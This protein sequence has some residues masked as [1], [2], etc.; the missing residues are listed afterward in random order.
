LQF[1]TI[2]SLQI[3][4]KFNLSQINFLNPVMSLTKNNISGSDSTN[5]PDTKPE[6]NQ[7]FVCKQDT[8]TCLIT[9]DRHVSAEAIETWGPFASQGEA[10]VRRVGLIRAG[11]CQPL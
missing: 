3:K 2:F 7:W 9:S 10:I 6:E 8:G 5:E 4:S 11:K 1:L